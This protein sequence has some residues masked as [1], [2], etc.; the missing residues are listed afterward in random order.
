MT[1]NNSILGNASNERKLQNIMK[2]KRLLDF[3]KV[4]TVQ[5]A[6]QKTG[7]SE[8]TIRSWCKQGNIP[9]F[10]PKKNTTV[11]P[12]TDQNKPKWLRG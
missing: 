2:L 10:D 9:L 5:S 12:L 11:V 4:Y 6:V 1:N 3:K 8:Q 7:Y